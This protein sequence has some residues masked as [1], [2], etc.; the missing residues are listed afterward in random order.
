[1]NLIVHLKGPGPAINAEFSSEPEKWRI[2]HTCGLTMGRC[3]GSKSAYFERNPDSDFIP[4][5]NVFAL[6]KGKLW[7]GDLDL[8]K[9]KPKLKAAAGQL[10]TVLYVLGEWDGRF[11][12]ASARPTD[13][14]RRARW[15]TGGSKRLTGI[16]T[17]CARNRISTTELGRTLGM[18]TAKFGRPLDPE[19]TYEFW[20]KA[21]NR[22]LWS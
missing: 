9:D 21:Y 7:W 14:L 20:R 13:I 22:G 3:F 16:R 5:A 2:F 1:M 6:R 18:P 12:K 10:R 4:N 11:E 8:A 19:E 17:L 15:H